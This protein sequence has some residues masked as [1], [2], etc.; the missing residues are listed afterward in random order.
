MRLPRV[1]P[2]ARVVYVDN[3]PLVLAHARALLAGGPGITVVEGDLRDPQAIL[4]S[5]AR[6]SNIALDQPV[7][8]LLTCVLHFL[9]APDADSAVA[10]FTTA[11]ADGS[12]LIISVGTSTGTDPA[13]IER[14][15][16]AYAGTTVV[17]ARSEHEIAAWLTS[18][19]LVPPGLVDVRA[20]RADWQQHKLTPPTARIIGVKE[21]DGTRRRQRPDWM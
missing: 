1:A 18:L 13:L 10:A 14:L 2:A 12:Y 11:I 19:D 4:G 3:D 5:P 7:C 8:V 17:T 15:R 9:A 6:R 21:A 16:S 20:W